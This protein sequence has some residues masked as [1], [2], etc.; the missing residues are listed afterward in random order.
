MKFE[1]LTIKDI[2]KALGLSTSTVSRA[3]RDSYEI[4]ADTKQLVLNYAQTH[5]YHPNPV[6]LGLKE[7][8]TKSIGVVVCEIDNSFFSQAING[9]ES[10]ANAEGYHTIIAQTM[11]SVEQE[12]LNV[13]FLA[14]RSV[15]GLI[16]SVSA[17]GKD[18]GY[19]QEL[20]AKGL[21]IVFF[22]RVVD[23]MDTFKIK[24]DNYTGAYEA[25]VELLKTG[26][27]K[28]AF[29]GG[30]I[31]LSVSGERFSGYRSALADF[32]C[33][34]DEALVRYCEFGGRELEFVTRFFDQAKISDHLPDAVFAGSDR[35]TVAC[36]RVL[37]L[38][39]P[40]LKHICI[41]GFSNAELIDFTYPPIATIRQPAFDMGVSA[42]KSL[43]H[44]M[45]TGLSQKAV[46]TITLPTSLILR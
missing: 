19:L 39:R 13:R 38:L 12:I 28:I 42:M 35:L 26:Y 27:K 16:M 22:D 41:T 45:Q 29:L 24:A 34:F 9:I 18:F 2:A 7:R 14:S 1:A 15:D 5:N 46:E 6:A 23:A 8:R 44:L 3:L 36:L 21:P 30:A 33:Q 43:I 11:E 40:E 4:S 25:A 20:S 10:V 32:D 31:G 17:S 37:R